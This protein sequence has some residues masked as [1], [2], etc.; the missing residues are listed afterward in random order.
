MIDCSSAEEGVLLV[1]VS[2]FWMGDLWWLDREFPWF[3]LLVLLFVE[4]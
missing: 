3:L 4:S 1:S 2:R